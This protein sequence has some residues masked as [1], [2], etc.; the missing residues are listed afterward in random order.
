[1]STLEIRIRDNKASFRPGEVLEG[2]VRWQ[3]DKNAQTMELRLFWHTEGKGDADISVEQTQRF[4]AP[5]LSGDGDF[6]FILP[7]APYTFSGRLISLIWALE[8]VALPG[9][10]AEICEFTLSPTGQE[11]VLPENKAIADQIKQLPP[12]L[13]SRVE[14][15]AL[16]K[17]RGVDTPTGTRDENPLQQRSPFD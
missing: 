7:G 12:W 6:R 4:E 8:L 5:S 2:T 17:T 9:E 13:K 15:H 16:G 10:E 3:L 14:K 1:M 11:V